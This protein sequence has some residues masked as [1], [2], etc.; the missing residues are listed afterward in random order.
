MDISIYPDFTSAVQ[1]ARKKFMDAKQKLRELNIPYAMLYPAR[2]KITI[3]GKTWIFT[4]SAVVQKFLKQ[5]G[6]PGVQR[7]LPRSEQGEQPTMSDVE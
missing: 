1:E 6:K 4:D 3:E 2:L 7:R 5:K